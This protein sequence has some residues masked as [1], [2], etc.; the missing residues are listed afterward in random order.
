MIDNWKD[1]PVGMFKRLL[2]VDTESEDR[3]FALVA[4]LCDTTVDD[5]L[6][7]PLPEVKEMI[8]R[9]KFLEKKP[10]V[11]IVKGEYRL[12]DT[13]YTFNP[14]YTDIVVNQY[15]DFVNTPKDV[16]HVSE[17]LSIFLIPKGKQYCKGYNVQ[18]VVQDIDQYLGYE[19]AN[20]LSAFFL[21]R[22][23]L[24]LRSVERVTR[25]ALKRAVKEKVITKEE[26]TEAMEKF[27]TFRQATIG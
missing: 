12:G 15:I 17:I 4:V 19:D 27:A 22:W 7:R 10:K 16:E 13:V 14:D 24:Y 18:K 8:E 3:A 23:V 6:D 2:D 9:T 1:M 5:I 20:S 21:G 26:A 25:K 11:R